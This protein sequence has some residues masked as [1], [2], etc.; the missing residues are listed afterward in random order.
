MNN[1]H[2]HNTEYE[3]IRETSMYTAATYISQA[4]SM[5]R[6]FVI[7][8]V[9]GPS[10]YGIWT[11]LRSFFSTIGY[12]SLGAEHAMVR[13][14]PM[15]EAQNNQEKKY[16]I[17]QTT[18]MW[19]IFVSLAIALIVSVCALTKQLA[20][21]R[22]EMFLAGL[23][24]VTNSINH[25]IPLKLKSEKKIFL[26]SKYVMLFAASNAIFGIALVFN[27]KLSGLLIGMLIAHCV[28][29]AYL[30]S[31][32]ALSFRF[33]LDF[34]L[35]KKLFSVG[36]PIMILNSAYFLMRNIDKF[37][38][39]LMLGSAMTGYYGL[40][41]FIAAA[42]GHIPHGMSVAL[43]PRMMNTYGKTQD[44]AKIEEYF[45][46]PLAVLSVVI[47]ILLGVI[48]LL[49]D[50]VVNYLL[51]AYIPAVPILRILIA[52]LYFRYIWSVPTNILIAFNKQRQLM[53]MMFA[54][55]IIG[56]ILDVIVIQLGYGIMGVAY[57]TLLIVFLV[58]VLGNM[59]ALHSLRKTAVYICFS[60]VKIYSPFLYVA[61]GLFFI[62]RWQ[63][64]DIRIVNDAI[65]AIIFIV[66]T[67]PLIYYLERQFQ[68]IRKTLTAFH[69]RK[70]NV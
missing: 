34:N 11:L 17:Q 40:A 60:L 23:V 43:F 2:R 29:V 55:L 13:E 52:G 48:F 7:A 50:V 18:L 31:K 44:R 26:L 49:I 68:I 20:Y 33:N 25:F 12:I 56:I 66:Y 14:V 6:G 59:Y 70:R 35:L 57:A 8:N 58:S 15:C 46:I 27:F 36:F 51:P 30:M 63:F 39:Y 16:S 10:S 24:Y 45:Q 64:S 62:M 53:V 37:I 69:L 4:I 41:A 67:L 42:L 65:Q 5:I 21:I 54:L 47:P 32:Q 38:V 19:N 22:V 1:K 3:I 61:V 28:V 9:L